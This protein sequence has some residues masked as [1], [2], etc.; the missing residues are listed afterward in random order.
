MS[1]MNLNDSPSKFNSPS[2]QSSFNPNPSSYEDRVLS[3]SGNYDLTMASNEY[4]IEEDLEEVVEAKE[5]K[6]QL[7]EVVKNYLRI[8]SG[9]IEEPEEELVLQSRMS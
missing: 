4:D 1:G 3:G 8:L 9:V 6:Q 5:D 2:T 7:K